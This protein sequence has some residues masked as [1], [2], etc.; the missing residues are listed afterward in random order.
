VLQTHLYGHVHT[1]RYVG[2]ADHA[3]CSCVDAPALS[4]ILRL[5]LTLLACACLLCGSVAVRDAKYYK[6]L[7][8]AEDADDRTIKKAYR[9]AA[10]C[11]CTQ[12]P[13]CT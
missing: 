12:N 5:L 9:K 6:V 8:I 11:A 3:S 1:T 10:L 13:A 2:V 7:D 4:M